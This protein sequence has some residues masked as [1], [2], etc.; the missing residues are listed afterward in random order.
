MTIQVKGS[1]LAPITGA[2]ANAEI[3]IV[4]KIN[5]GQTTKNSVSTTVTSS[6]GA[7]DFPLVNGNHLIAVKYSGA[8]IF[9]NLGTV[10]VGD[11]SPSQIDLITL[12]ASFNTEPDPILVN[13]LQIIAGQAAE[14]AQL[15]TQKA[16]E[17]SEAALTATEQATIA[18]EQADNVRT[19]FSRLEAIKK[20][21]TLS[22]DFTKN[23]HKEYGVFGL[24]KKPLTEILTTTRSTVATYVSPFGIEE[25]PV[26][27]PRID[28][29]PV[30]GE[31]L[32]LLAE[33]AATNL[34]IGPIE[35][36]TQD[37]AVTAQ[38]YTL[39]FYGTGSISLSGAHSGE[40]VG[41]SG[42]KRVSLT[43]TA[44][45][46]VLSLTVSGLVNYAQLE[47]G[48]LATSYI[49]SLASPT[50]RGDDHPRVL[51]AVSGLTHGSIYLEHIHAGVPA[52]LRTQHYYLTGNLGERWGL[53]LA[54][55]TG[56]LVLRY[57]AGDLAASF[58]NLLI[59]SDENLV[60]GR[61]YRTCLTYSQDG[62]VFNYSMYL[63]GEEVAN[64]SFNL[65][66]TDTFKDLF[67]GRTTRADSAI[68]VN[69]VRTCGVFSVELT[70][71]EAVLLT[72]GG[73]L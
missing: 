39:S 64:G 63:D 30:T 49:A 72:S 42:K 59:L 32:G 57:R 22:L 18:T 6:T 60:A 70:K 55:T 7:Y 4:S 23:E 53:G 48:K 10:S 14:S 65:N 40:L 34:F 67:L 33:S 31:P 51:N 9:T 43:F 36:Q 13:Q 16:S 11:D 3:K 26:N 24:E 44:S 61:P 41:E 62:G 38:V 69:V 8:S 17:S 45:E 37:I 5:Y 1:L 56:G 47:T 68:G 27:T 46:G 58:G 71:Q 20:K 73:D 28:Y 25:S 66:L 15:A 19:L 35:A 21:A 52:A 2:Q 29:D 12:L 54:T 50:T